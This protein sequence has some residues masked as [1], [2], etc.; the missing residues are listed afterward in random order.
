MNMNEFDFGDRPDL[1]LHVS[2]TRG[3]T[4]T[5]TVNLYATSKQG[6]N[7]RFNIRLDLAHAQ[8]LIDQLIG[9]CE[10]I[11]DDML[12]AVNSPIQ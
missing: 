2:V 5:P 6:G 10:M 9:S 12:A 4:V 11:E 8:Q 1:D 7:L 3:P